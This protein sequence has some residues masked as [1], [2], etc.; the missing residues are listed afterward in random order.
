[1][2][3]T[4]PRR[5]DI[6]A[7]RDSRVTFMSR[8]TFN[9]L[10]DTNLGFNR[11]LLVQLNERLGVFIALI[12][13]ER[14]RHPDAR[15]ARSLGAQFSTVLYPV[16]GRQIQISQEEIGFLAGVSRQRVNEALQVLEKAA[17]LRVDYGGVTVVDLQGLE[18]FGA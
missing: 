4:E 18:G 6:M 17:M 15:V 14:F 7:L 1:M 10:L 3:K 5:H 8:A 2:L 9:R 11:F 12:E 13:N 16:I